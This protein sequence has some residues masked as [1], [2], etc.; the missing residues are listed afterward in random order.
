VQTFKPSDDLIPFH[1]EPFY[2]SFIGVVSEFGSGK[3][4]V[5]KA[6]L[7]HKIKMFIDKTVTIVNHK[8]KGSSP[9]HLYPCLAK[10]PASP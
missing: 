7:S 4:N 2:I 10:S 1:C 9:Y 3:I 8:A 6:D 5:G